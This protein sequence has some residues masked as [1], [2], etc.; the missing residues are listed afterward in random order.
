MSI[1]TA[2]TNIDLLWDV[3]LEEP[4][5]KNT[6]R[7]KKEMM[8]TALNNN[9]QK[10]YEKEKNNYPD[11]ISLNK[12]F[13]SQMLKVLRSDSVITKN[14]NINT[15]ITKPQNNELYKVEDIQARR[16]QEF[17]QNLANRQNEFDSSMTFNRPPVPNFAEKIED[18][19]IKGMDELIAKTV[20]QRN[21]EIS[22]IHNQDVSQN[23]SQDPIKY[24][25][26][27]QSRT[28]PITEDIIELT[29]QKKHDPKKLSWSNEV[30][31]NYIEPY[32]KE[33]NNENILNK[34]KKIPFEEKLSN[35]SQEYNVMLTKMNSMDLKIDLLTEHVNK[36]LNLCKENNLKIN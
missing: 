22:Q 26:I 7:A 12:T 17:Q 15:N 1:F 10:F 16:Q 2:K 18:E 20:A 11:L 35:Y 31:V 8:Y 24:I 23:N 32:Y 27:D 28:I 13:L 19:K 21:F 4:V 29:D 3:L 33:V 6:T 5:I 14:T 36:I 34:F 30:E 25:K 9:I